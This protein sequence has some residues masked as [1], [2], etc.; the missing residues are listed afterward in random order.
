[1]ETGKGAKSSRMIKIVTINVNNYMQAGG[2]R[3]VLCVAQKIINIYSIL[4]ELC[5]FNIILQRHNL[6]MKNIKP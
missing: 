2:F 1:M 5:G 3:S 4:W 6:C